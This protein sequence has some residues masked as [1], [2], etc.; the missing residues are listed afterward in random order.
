MPILK[1]SKAY[2][3][4]SMLSYI[5]SDYRIS[6]EIYGESGKLLSGNSEEILAVANT[7]AEAFKTRDGLPRYEIMTTA[8]QE[9]FVEDQKQITGESWNYVIGYSSP[10]TL[11]YDITLNGNT[12]LITYL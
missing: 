7:W 6:Y 8:M 5:L 12:V 4:Y 3:T 1:G 9:Q 10:K 11:S 2:I